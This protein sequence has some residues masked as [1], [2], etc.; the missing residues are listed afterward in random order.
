MQKDVR[1]RVGG[2]N[3]SINLTRDSFFGELDQLL[4]L[5]ISGLDVIKLSAHTDHLQVIGLRRS[6][7]HHGVENLNACLQHIVLTCDTANVFGT[8]LFGRL[9]EDDHL[10]LLKDPRGVDDKLSSGLAV[11]R[12]EVQPNQYRR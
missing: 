7:S 8:K 10:R 5:R 11:G 3:A 6:W 12:R 4:L 1:F 2:S 9:V